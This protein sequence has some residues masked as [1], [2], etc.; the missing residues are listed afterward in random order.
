MYSAFPP[1]IRQHPALSMKAKGGRVDKA[2]LDAIL[3]YNINKTGVDGSNQLLYYPFQRKTMKWWKK[4]FSPL[5]IMAVVNVYIIFKM[6]TKKP[7][8]IA[9]FITALGI[10]LSEKGGHIINDPPRPNPSADTAFSGKNS[11]YCKQS[12]E[13]YR[14]EGEERKYVVL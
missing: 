4:T 5:L 9:P 1:N 10:K 3:D 12:Q 6:K 11:S 13:N 2:K 14:E 7:V 8:R